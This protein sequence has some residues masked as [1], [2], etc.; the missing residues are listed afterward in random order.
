MIASFPFIFEHCRAFHEEMERSVAKKIGESFLPLW[1]EFFRLLEKDFLRQ[2]KSHLRNYKFSQMGCKLDDKRRMEVKA[3]Q[4]DPALSPSER[5]RLKALLRASPKRFTSPRNLKDLVQGYERVVADAAEMTISLA[6]HLAVFADGIRAGQITQADGTI[7]VR[8]MVRGFNSPKKIEKIKAFWEK[9]SGE[10]QKKLVDAWVLQ[11][12]YVIRARSKGAFKPFSDLLLAT[13]EEVLARWKR[14]WPVYHELEVEEIFLKC[15]NAYRRRD[16][17]TQHFIHYFNKTMAEQRRN[18]L[19]RGRSPEIGCPMCHAPVPW[20]KRK[21]KINRSSEWRTL[22]GDAET[23]WRKKEARGIQCPHCRA[24]FPAK[25]FYPSYA[26]S[27]YG[28]KP[29]KDNTKIIRAFEEK[30]RVETKLR[31]S[32]ERRHSNRTFNKF[33]ERPAAAESKVIISRQKLR[34]LSSLQLEVLKKVTRKRK[35]PLFDKKIAKDLKRSPGVIR[36]TK[37]KLRRKGLL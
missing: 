20:P 5:G 21:G 31:D 29:G 32:I 26:G 36:Q 17:R 4:K 7:F 27:R 10:N 8:L 9:F 18:F 25:R 24:Y 13:H 2:N 28:K 11:R 34:N 16:N 6:D 1:N 22:K 12:Q 30:E 35:R 19:S 33:P 23:I 37:L 15:L 3:L 14:N